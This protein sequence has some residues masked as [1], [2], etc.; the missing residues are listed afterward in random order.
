VQ[1]GHD[2]RLVAMDG[3]RLFDLIIYLTLF[4]NT[5]IYFKAPALPVN[6]KIEKI[7]FLWHGFSYIDKN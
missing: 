5:K 7:S 1:Q 3:Q 6:I 4:F 2:E